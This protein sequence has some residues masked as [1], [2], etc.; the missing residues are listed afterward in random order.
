MT[1][2]EPADANA[3]RTR[4]GYGAGRE[5]LLNAAIHVVANAGLRDLTYRAVAKEAGV[6]HG[7][8]AH[9]FGSRDALLAEALAYAIDRSI[10][11]SSLRAT[12]ARVEDF[13]DDL[14][15]LVTS[16]PDMQA[17]QYELLLESRRRPELVP[18]TRKLYETYRAASREG[19]RNLGIDDEALSHLVYAT[20]DGL[21]MQQL[22]VGDDESTR[23]H[24]RKLREVLEAVKLSY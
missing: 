10:E 2:R 11:A 1:S 21:V 18:L 12:T 22:T 19:L 17:F 7:L 14:T 13:V 8:V 5:A 4:P 15:E 6:T 23:R 3:P 9:H 20:L 16:N 24:V